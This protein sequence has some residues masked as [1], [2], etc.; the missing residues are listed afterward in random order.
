MALHLQLLQHLQK[1]WDVSLPQNLTQEELQHQLAQY[2]NQLINND[3][4]RLLNL[5]YRIDVNE[6]KLKASLKEFQDK[7][8][9]EVIATLII[10]RLLQKIKTREQ[11]KKNGNAGN[12][13]DRF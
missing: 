7:D 4:S 10:E 1:E 11:N 9:A 8:A 6:E 2:I 3:F 13:E 12:E 5:L